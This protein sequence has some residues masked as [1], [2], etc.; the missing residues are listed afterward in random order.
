MRRSFLKADKTSYPSTRKRLM[1]LKLTAGY[2]EQSSCGIIAESKQISRQN[3]D[4]YFGDNYCL[5]GGNHSVMSGKNKSQP[6]VF[7]EDMLKWALL[8]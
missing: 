6:M 7:A 5:P 2:A 3:S 8:R 4:H 1:F